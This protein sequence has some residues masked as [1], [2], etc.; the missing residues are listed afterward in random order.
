MSITFF[1]AYDSYSC[2]V[3]PSFSSSNKPVIIIPIINVIEISDIKPPIS[4]DYPEF[5]ALF[6]VRVFYNSPTRDSS[7]LRESFRTLIYT[8]SP[9]GIEDCD[10]CFHFSV[11]GWGLGHDST[12][13]L[14]AI[15]RSIEGLDGS[16]GKDYKALS[17]FYAGLFGI[18][19]GRTLIRVILCSY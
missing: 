3:G 18:S 4:E 7:A 12:Y 1:W 8:S 6:I 14:G 13:G 9:S 19:Y 5:L 17:V 15:D 16:N 2:F 10:T 11:D